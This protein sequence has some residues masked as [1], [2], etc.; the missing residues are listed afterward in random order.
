MHQRGP[1]HFKN[2]FGTSFSEFTPGK[3]PLFAAKLSQESMIAQICLKVIWPI[4]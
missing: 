3:L 4:I 2:G 1:A